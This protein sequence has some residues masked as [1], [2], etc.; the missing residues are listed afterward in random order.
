MRLR[1]A[2]VLIAGAVVLAGCGCVN[3]GDAA[4]DAA[5]VAARELSE[6]LGWRDR[7]RDAEY[8]AAS[9]I[10]AGTVDARPDGTRITLT[11][12]AWSG[13]VF[14]D[15]KAT[16]D[17]RFDVTVPDRQPETIAHR[18]NLAGSATVCFRF[19]LEL[20]A[21]TTF[22]GADCPEGAPPVPSPSPLLRLPADAD[23]RLAAVLRTATPETLQ[24][25]VRAA[26][27][28]E[29]IGVETAVHNGTLVAAVGV[30]R[31]RD[32]VVMIREP[33]GK[34]EEVGYDRVQ[35]EPGEAGCGTGL[36]THPVR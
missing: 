8:I 31:E 15:E 10:E 3:G 20:Y 25:A 36:Y 4:R 26:F 21:D 6:E 23:D 12:V 35:L 27:P 2:G 30:A 24:S 7:V 22:R 17:V 11:P 9:E 18:G 16:I 14:A 1:V 32:C 33:G 13:R 5:E 28:Q 29:G 34:T 19:T